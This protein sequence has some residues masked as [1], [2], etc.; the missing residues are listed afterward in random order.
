M[1]PPV[2]WVVAPVQIKLGDSL[3]VLGV[4]LDSAL[5]MNAHV[6]E[7]V[8]GHAIFISEHFAMFVLT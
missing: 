2:P 8:T 6:N 5:T 7:V 1:S 4:K 3:K